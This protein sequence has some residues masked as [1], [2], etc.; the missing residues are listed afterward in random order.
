M[1]TVKLIALDRD[2]ITDIERELFL[3]DLKAV[4]GEY[5]DIDGDATMEATRSENGFI[6][7]VIFSARR[8]KTIRRPS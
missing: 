2:D 5:F 4:A 1:N 7:C 8:V 6:V 3:K